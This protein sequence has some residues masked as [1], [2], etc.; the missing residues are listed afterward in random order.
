M[1]YTQTLIQ[2]TLVMVLGMGVVFFFLALLV[3]AMNI[4]SRVL[5]KYA[6]PEPAPAAPHNNNNNAV[7]TVI[8]AAMKQ[9]LKDKKK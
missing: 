2:A 5:A 4:M 6:T 1:P 3:F 7:V 9:Y 8:T